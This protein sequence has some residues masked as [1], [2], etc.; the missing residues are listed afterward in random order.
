[1]SSVALVT[2]CASARLG[3][4]ANSTARAVN[5]GG[6]SDERLTVLVGRRA[7]R[8]VVAAEVLVYE[9]DRHAPLAHCGRHSLHGPEAYVAAGE[10]SG[11]AAFQQVRIAVQCPCSGRP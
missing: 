6:L 4:A 7:G 2:K 5:S 11:H 1:M 8:G 10:D 3:A 9:R